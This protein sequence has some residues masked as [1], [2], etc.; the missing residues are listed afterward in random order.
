MFI[1]AGGIKYYRNINIAISWYLSEQEKEA[2]SEKGSSLFCMMERI[3]HNLSCLG[4]KHPR[5]PSSLSV[6]GR[7]TDSNERERQIVNP[8]TRC[9]IRLAKLMDL[10]PLVRNLVVRPPII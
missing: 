6:L 4:Y 2:F 3:L 10:F 5:C 7:T 9:K 1:I 8:V